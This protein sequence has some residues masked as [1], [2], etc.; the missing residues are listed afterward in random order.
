[1]AAPSRHRLR[2]ADLAPP[3][4]RASRALAAEVARRTARRLRRA[5]RARAATPELAAR[6]DDLAALLALLPRDDRRR[7]LHG[8]DLRGLLGEVE[9][10]GEIARLAARSRAARRGRAA[11]ERALFD[12]VARTEHLVDLVPAGRLDR[13]FAARAARLA[14]RRLREARADLE[15]LLLG[16]RLAFP[17]RPAGRRGRRRVRHLLSARAD[18]ER[19]RPAGRIDLATF[20][21]P[22]GPLGIEAGGSA[23]APRDAGARPGARARR[24]GPLGA[25]RAALLEGPG[26]VTLLLGASGVRPIAFPAAGSALLL[27]GVDG[28]PASTSPDSPLRL[29]RRRTIPGTPIVLAPALTS[30]PRRLRVGRDVPGLARRLARA[31]RL[32]HLAWPEAHDEIVRRTAMVVPVREAGLVSWSLAARPG[33]SFINVFGKGPV[34]LADDL[35]HETAHHLLHDLQEVR[36]LLAPGADTEETQAFASPGRGALRPLHGLLHGAFTFQ[37]RAALF[38]RILRARAR[39]P[40]VVG[41]LLGRGR[42]AFLRR[43]RRR[44]LGMIAHAH[45]E[46]EVAAR[47]RLLTADGAALARALARWR[48]QVARGG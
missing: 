11:C 40:G 21:G 35:L 5:V 15:A 19:G 17:Q 47:A 18:P 43:E 22:A 6:L 12:R 8:P 48:R 23:G 37:F 27:P 1:M 44:E 39:L 28:R 20:G 41:P 7:V 3:S 38:D 42:V 34:A 30:T 45:R 29:T 32:V 26:G 10:W 9:T 13:R 14:A 4:P 46:L 36:A 2:P 24:G 31:L 16:A 25:V 33:V